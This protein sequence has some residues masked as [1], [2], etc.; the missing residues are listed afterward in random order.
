[1]ASKMNFSFTF[2][3]NFQSN[4][5]KDDL[6]RILEELNKKSTKIGFWQ[7]K[8]YNVKVE[9]PVFEIQWLMRTHQTG[10]L[11][12]KIIGIIKS[13]EPLIINI[14]IVPNYWYFGIILIINLFILL[15]CKLSN[16]TDTAIFM[17]SI[18]NILYISITINS[19]SKSKKWI[20]KKLHL[21]RFSTQQN[22]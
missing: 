5:T 2:S 15:I 4:L 10:P 14:E 16:N 13:N 18:F 8:D 6:H 3:D 7:V 20:C 12:P 22:R 19:I 21:S 17:C 9:F 11:F 1:M